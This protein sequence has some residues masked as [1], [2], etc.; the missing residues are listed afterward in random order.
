MCTYDHREVYVPHYVSING[1]GPARPT[2][3]RVIT[4]NPS[5]Y[6]WVPPPMFPLTARPLR[7]PQR[8]LWVPPPMFPLTYY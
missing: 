5:V 3:A 7:G 4:G 8:P 1:E 6:L 2:E